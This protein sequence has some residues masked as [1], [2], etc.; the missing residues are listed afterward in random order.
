MSSVCLSVE[1]YD[2]FSVRNIREGRNV[3]QEKQ[4]IGENLPMESIHRDAFEQIH[5]EADPANHQWHQS[6]YSD[7]QLYSEPEYIYEIDSSVGDESY[8]NG[9]SKCSSLRQSHLVMAEASGSSYPT[10]ASPAEVMLP[11]PMDMMSQAM[12]EPSITYLLAR[13]NRVISLQHVRTDISILN[14]V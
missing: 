7:N 11:L 12:F 2:F 3:E 13:K 14:K 4:S 6:N 1:S 5:R 9:N 8:H 10:Y